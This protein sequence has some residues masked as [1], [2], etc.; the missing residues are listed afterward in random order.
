MGAGEW[1][2]E[3]KKQLFGPWTW[4]QSGECAH[5]PSS[6]SFPAENVWLPTRAWPGAVQCPPE[7]GWAGLIQEQGQEEASS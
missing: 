2:Q 4:T 6:L 5:Q 7:T 3:A 1:V